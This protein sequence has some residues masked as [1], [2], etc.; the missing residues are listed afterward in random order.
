MTSDIGL[1]FIYCLVVQRKH[2]WKTRVALISNKNLFP[3]MLRRNPKKIKKINDLDLFWLTFVELR[4]LAVACG[5][6]LT[7][8]GYWKKETTKYGV[9]RFL[10]SC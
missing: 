8:H 9:M 1:D 3:M 7:I 4:T 2:D 5:I 6:E 10:V